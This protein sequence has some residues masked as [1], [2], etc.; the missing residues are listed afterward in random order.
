MNSERET[1]LFDLDGV[2]VMFLQT[3]E[4]DAG[5]L[6]ANIWIRENSGMW[7]IKRNNKRRLKVGMVEDGMVAPDCWFQL[8][9]SRFPVKKVLFER[10]ILFYQSNNFEV[11]TCI[12]DLKTEEV[13]VIQD[14]LSEHC[15]GAVVH[16]STQRISH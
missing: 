4:D 3:Y 10:F 16:R 7:V 5:V 8:H 2:N 9:L 1:T 11:Q 13:K 6:K 15:Y 14:L 12:F